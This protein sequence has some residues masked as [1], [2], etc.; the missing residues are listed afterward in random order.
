MISLCFRGALAI[1]FDRVAV[2]EWT[3]VM[4]EWCCERW[5][6]ESGEGVGLV[7]E[8]RELRLNIADGRGMVLAVV[9][10]VM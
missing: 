3:S 10:I 6:G 8:A 2:L 5:W 7:S 4:R 9:S 1:R